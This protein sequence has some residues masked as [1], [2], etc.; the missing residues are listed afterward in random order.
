MDWVPC[1]AHLRIKIFSSTCV[2]AVEAWW[3][4]HI[5]LLADPG[6]ARGC[7]TNN[8][9]TNWLIKWLTN[10]LVPTALR[11]RHTQTVRDR[12]SSYKIDYIIGIKI[13]LNFKGYQNPISGSKVMAIDWRGGFCLLVELQRGRVCSCSLRSRLVFSINGISITLQHMK[14]RHNSGLQQNSIN[15]AQILPEL[16]KNLHKHCLHAQTIFH[17]CP[18]LRGNIEEFYFSIPLLRMI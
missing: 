14:L 15:L 6:K 13:F 3:I 2:E 17:L 8:S 5:I 12:S 1:E 4:Y 16:G 9:V 11:R 10:P 18:S 7:S